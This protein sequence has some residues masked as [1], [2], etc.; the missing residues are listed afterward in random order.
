MQL[1]LDFLKT[2]TKQKG[3]PTACLRLSRDP[4]ARTLSLPGLRRQSSPEIPWRLWGF[5]QPYPVPL[6][7]RRTGNHKSL[8]FPAWQPLQA[9]CHGNTLAPPSLVPLLPWQ[10][11]PVARGTAQ[12]LP[13][14]SPPGGPEWAGCRLYKTSPS[15]HLWSPPPT[16]AGVLE[17]AMALN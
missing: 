15:F 17:R 13:R 3:K 4:S 6:L 16:R 8:I 5:T 2:L 14:G 7:P 10:W 1:G 11:P 12:A 9:G